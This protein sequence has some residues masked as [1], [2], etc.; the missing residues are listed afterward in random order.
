MNTASSKYSIINIFEY[1]NIVSS[2]EYSIIN[3]LFIMKIYIN[4]LINL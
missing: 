4:M 1:N 3:A 2:D